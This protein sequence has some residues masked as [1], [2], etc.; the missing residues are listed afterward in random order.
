MNCRFCNKN[1][2]QKTFTSV[3]QSIKMFICSNCGCHN[4][5][6]KKMSNYNDKDTYWNNIKD[7]DGNMRNHSSDYEI[8]FKTKNFYGDISNYINSFDNP[9]VLDVGCGLG[10]LLIGLNTKFKSCL[11]PSSYATKMIKKKYND[12]K[13]FNFS[14]ISIEK[15]DEDFDIIVAY[16]LIEHLNDPVKLIKDLK[17]KL[18]KNGKLIIG[19]PLIGTIISNYFGKYYR[20]YNKNHEILFNLKSLKKL[21]NN[22]NFKII[23]IEKPYFKTDYFNFK[24]TL[25]LFNNK[26]ISPP[27]YGS[28]VTI[29][30]ENLNS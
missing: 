25:R 28:I 6:E 30:S 29:Y 10:S 4:K 13:I 12:I 21:L 17:K 23:K 8:K 1:Y 11:E 26:K 15:I 3:N 22:N 24:N 14:S 18:K 2:F 9:K 16:H 20:N 5:E 19:T 7:P 27:F